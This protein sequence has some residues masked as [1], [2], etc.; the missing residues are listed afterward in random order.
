M[1]DG[2]VLGNTISDAVANLMKPKFTQDLEKL[3][4][5]VED[6]WNE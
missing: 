3:R 1:T 4:K 2:T 6:K 5:Q